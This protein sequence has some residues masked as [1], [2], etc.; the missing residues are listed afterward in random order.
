M[1]KV[2]YTDSEGRLSLRL[3]PDNTPDTEAIVGAIVGPPPLESLGLPKDIE[4]K[5][6]NELFVRGIFTES[7]AIR[8]RSE[9]VAALQAALKVDAGKIVNIYSGKGIGNGYEEPSEGQ[10]DKTVPH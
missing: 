4:V 10:S 6:N 5:L 2:K 8:R 7:D 3:I 9:V 1:R